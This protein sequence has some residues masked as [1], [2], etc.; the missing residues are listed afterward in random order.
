M[1]NALSNPTL[2]LHDGTGALI[3]SNDNWQ[4]A[5]N[6]RDIINTGLAPVDA[7]ESAILTTLS[8][9]SS[10][11]AATVPCSGSRYSGAATSSVCSS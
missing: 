8:A 10:G 11:Q 7:N 3:A 5:T 1:T 4:N 2:E 9:T 6:K